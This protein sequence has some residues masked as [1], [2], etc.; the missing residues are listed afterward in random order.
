MKNILFILLI[1]CAFIAK[2][3]IV[4]KENLTEKD[5]LYWDFKKTKLQST[6]AYYKDILGETRD[7]HGKWE[8]FNEFGDNEEIR[9]YYREKLHGQV[10]L[11]YANGKPRQEGYFKLDKQD[12]IYREWVEN[13]TLIVEGKYK[14]GK[15]FGI[16]R[17]AR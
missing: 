7:K 11:K 14:N 8:Y 6:G 12:S 4:K 2:A 9:N 15:P 3:Q 13:G 16:W 5:K 1:L 10:F 17:N